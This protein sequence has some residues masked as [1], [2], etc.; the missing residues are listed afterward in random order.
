MGELLKA[1]DKVS[2]DRALRSEDKFRSP[3]EAQPI[4]REEPRVHLQSSRVRA[5]SQQPGRARSESK[6]RGKHGSPDEHMVSLVAPTSFE[7]ERI[8]AL[9]HQV[10]QMHKDIGLSVMVVTSPTIGD[11]KSF[12]AVN[13]A[14]ALAQNPTA[15]ILLV[16]ADLRKPTIH[17]LL[18][19]GTYPDG[20]ATYVLNT[21]VSLADVVVTRSEFNLAVL[22]GGR[23]PTSPYEVLKSPRFQALLDEAR[24]HYDY[25]VMDA[26]PVLAC[27]DCRLM[28]NNVDGFFVVVS[29]HT[30]PR[31][32]VDEALDELDQE[33]VLGLI[34]NRQELDRQYSSYYTSSST[35]NRRKWGRRLRR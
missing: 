33:K 4:K 6:R 16:D 21:R 19:M 2:R 34:F 12:I 17:S 20:L 26:P 27:P 31:K 7:A 14:G 23:P 30:T 35:T 32:L 22:P 29:A 13:L 11:G 18:G 28:E 1:V 25:V 3:V 10:E 9:R 8:R 5:Q 15:R 24:R